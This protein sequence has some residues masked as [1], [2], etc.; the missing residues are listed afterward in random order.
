MLWIVRT[1]FAGLAVALP[2]ASAFAS[3]VP[4]VKA[5]EKRVWPSVSEDSPFSGEIEYSFDT[6]LNK[7]SARF[8]TS[9]ASRNILV[10]VLFGPPAVHT[11][12]AVYEFRGRVPTDRPDSVRLSLMSDE[13]RQSATEYRQSATHYS[14]SFGVEPILVVSIGDTVIRYP[15]RIAQRV[16][17]WEAANI[18]SSGS[19][20]SRGRE[21]TI[22][23]PHLPREIHIERTGTALIPICDFLALVYARNVRGTVAGLDFELNDGVVSGLRAFAAQ[24]NLNTAA[25][26][27][28]NCR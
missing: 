9:L 26:D 17:E 3:V 23:L 4:Q 2:F 1:G 7:T 28:V 24:T 14:P 15:L 25:R 21:P 8:K 6:A 10:R 11:L 18:P 20:P 27:G 12:V 13:Y 22:N 5:S 16:D 19:H